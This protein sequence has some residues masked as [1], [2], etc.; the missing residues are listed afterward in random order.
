MV[1]VLKDADFSANNIGQIEIDVTIDEFTEAAITASG[2]SSM[3]TS[4][5]NAL[6]SYFKTLGAFGGTGTIWNKL[7]FLWLPVISGDLAHSFV[8]YKDNVVSATP[9]SSYWAL[10]NN[11]IKAVGSPS[12]GIGF[13]A[14][15]APNKS[16]LSIFGIGDNAV[17]FVRVGSG[18]P[19]RISIRQDIAGN[20]NL[21]VNVQADAGTQIVS[22]KFSDPPTADTYKKLFGISIYGSGNDN[23][24]VLDENGVVTKTVRLPGADINTSISLMRDVGTINSSERGSVKLLAIGTHLSSAEM[25]QMKTACEALIDAFIE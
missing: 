17:R 24:L 10:Q 14:A 3:T 23:G 12:D 11:G 19:G 22:M 1:I 15:A 20:G 21:N 13:T 25:T 18:N 9:N 6:N 4:Q 7:T 2:N 8:N 5:Q 16:D